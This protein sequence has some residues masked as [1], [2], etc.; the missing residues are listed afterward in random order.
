MKTVIFCF[1]LMFFSIFKTQ[2]KIAGTYH[3]SSGN[4]DD[5]VY[6]WVLMENHEFAMFTFGQII[7]GKWEINDQDEISFQ[8]NT[9]KYPFDVYGRF[10][11][12]LKGTKIMFSNFSINEDAFLGNSETEIQPVLNPDANCL[13]YPLV[14]NFNENF[15]DIVFS[16]FQYRQ[17]KESFYKADFQKYNDFMIMYYSSSVMVRPFKAVLKDEKLYFNGRD[18]RPSSERKEINP[19][20]LKEMEMYISQGASAVSKEKIVANKSYNVISYGI[21]ESEE[22]FDEE[23]FLK[24]NY[25]FDPSTEIYT[26]KNKYKVSKDDEYHDLNIL[27]QYHKIELHPTQDSYKKSPKSIFNITCKN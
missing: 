4:P 17:E 9:P 19:D 2:T 23:S 26:A 15:K 18:E 12:K 10:D 25:N 27:Y 24:F 7:S 13:P 5:G 22:K 21:G 20:E 16:T 8:P 14:K 1:F 6:N 11:P 3:V